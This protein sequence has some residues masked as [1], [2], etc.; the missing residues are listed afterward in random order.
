MR[1]VRAAEWTVKQRQHISPCM[2]VQWAVALMT[3]PNLKL[4]L[5]EGII[6][7]NTTQHAWQTSPVAP[8]PTATVLRPTRYAHLSYRHE[9]RSSYEENPRWNTTPR[10]MYPRMR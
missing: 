4:V 6:V 2:F 3:R 10:S 8:A 7:F 9:K 5:R 1:N